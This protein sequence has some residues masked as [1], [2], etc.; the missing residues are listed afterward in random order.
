MWAGTGEVEEVD[1]S[2]VGGAGVVEVGADGDA[3]SGDGDGGTEL[4]GGGWQGIAEDVCGQ[5]GG[6]A[7]EVVDVSDAGVGGIGVILEGTDD[8][9]AA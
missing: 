6:G 9:A 5:S 3:G 7:C 4:V 2:G 8:D 1:R